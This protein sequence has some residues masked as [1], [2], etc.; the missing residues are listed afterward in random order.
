MG[1]IQKQSIRSTFIIMFGFALGAFNIL[2]LAPQILTAEQLGLTRMIT[3]I[4]L[5]MATFCT[6]GS[7]P[8][9]YKFFPFYQSYL[10]AKKNDLPFVTLVICLLGFTLM[11]IIGH[12]LKPVIIRKYS[13]QSKLFVDYYYLVYPFCLF[14]LLYMWMECFAWSFKKTVLSNTIKETTHRLIFVVLMVLFATGLINLTQL[15]WIFSFAYLPAVLLLLWSLRRSEGFALVPHISSVTRRMKGRMANFGLF[16]FGAQF[17]NLLSKT[18]DTMIIAAKTENG[19]AGAA[20]FT[21]A[22]YVVTLMEIPQR[23]ITSISIPIL[24]ESWRNKDMANINHIYN[25]S[26]TNLLVVGLIM[27][28]L[29]LLNSHNFEA[30]LSGDYKGIGTVIFFMGIGKLIDLGTGANAQI[31]GTSSYWKTDFIFN[32]VYTSLAIPLNYILISHYGL[33]GAAYSSLL[34]L[35][36][37]NLMRFSFLWYK[38][39]QQPYTWKHLLVIMLAL[40]CGLI[41]YAL[42]EMHLQMQL[43]K[44]VRRAPDVCVRSLV[45]LA[46]FIPG[47]Y[48]FRISDEINGLLKKYTGMAF[49]WIKR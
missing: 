23:S 36:F 29:T 47:L 17:L 10:P 2:L 37:F 44:V 35:T 16:L 30:S 39:K 6:F 41:A 49:G 45:F 42:P 24:S 26:V 33:I 43:P 28:S 8:V 11:L 46:L 7:L 5:T 31:I 38:F 13:T 19:L 34:S 9:I 22:T 40:V 18:S 27:F 48:Y 15:L 3:D 25:K 20:V 32:A 14:M 21:I 1:I 4:G 12:F